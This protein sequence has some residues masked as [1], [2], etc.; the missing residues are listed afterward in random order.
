MN[1]SST[2]INQIY[3]RCLLRS[4]ESSCDSITVPGLLAGAH[5]FHQERLR[6]EY[7]SV[8]SAIKKLPRRMLH[9]NNPAGLPWII[10][11]SHGSGYDG[12]TLETAERLVVMGIA[13]GII[14]IV[15][16]ELPIMDM[17]YIV[18]DDDRLIREERM[19]PRNKQR[20]QVA[21]WRR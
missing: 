13:L 2:V 20:R 7:S 8:F 5:T 19:Q 12:C 9:S 3:L 17:P 6:S 21:R 4:K 14:R 10:A 1:I 16:S 15:Q 18:V 11:R